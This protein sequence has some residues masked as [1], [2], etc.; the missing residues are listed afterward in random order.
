M[1]IIDNRE[2]ASQVP[3]LLERL[4]VPFNFSTLDVGDYLIG[5]EICVERKTIDDYISSLLS[6]RLHQELYKMS[7]T[8]ELSY[9]AIIGY[10]S[11]AL[12]MR[13]LSRALI[14]SSLVGT[15]FKRAPDGKMGHISLLA[16]LETEYDFALSLKFLYKK[17]LEQKPRLPSFTK[18]NIPDED[19]LVYILSAFPNIGEVRAKK[20]L[21]KFGT[22]SNIANASVQQL[23]EV[24]GEK[25][26]LNLFLWMHKTYT[27]KK[28]EE[29]TKNTLR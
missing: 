27:E 2:K 15:A 29:K 6:G 24:I 28:D 11:V 18:I 12:Q 16:P 13:N 25:T 20:L 1:I 26:G 21:S 10:P 8:Y 7:Y 22:I 3:K 9:L 5:Q 17:Y 14:I 23:A 4:Q 19:R